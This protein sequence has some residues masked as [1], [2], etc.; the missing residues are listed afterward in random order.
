M[1]YIVSLIAMMGWLSL[2]VHDVRADTLSQD[3]T[4]INQ[5]N[6]TLPPFRSIWKDIL[7]LKGT[8]DNAD[9]ANRY[10]AIQEDITK[11]RAEIFAIGQ[12]TGYSAA[13]NKL[14][15]AVERTWGDL[16]VLE[17]DEALVY[18]LDL[19]GD[20]AGGTSVVKHLNSHTLS[21]DFAVI[22]QLTKARGWT[23]TGTPPGGLIG[24]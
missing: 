21:G 13:D 8:G 16:E 15:G 19:D 10:A 20:Y 12:W 2:S 4:M 18:V 3:T 1:R 23:S 5:Y 17:E 7:S 11:T 9:L 22:D 6:A 24:A 14:R